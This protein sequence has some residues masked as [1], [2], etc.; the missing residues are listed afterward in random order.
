MPPPSCHSP[1]LCVPSS[2]HSP[3]LC[4]PSCHSP[5]LSVPSSSHSPGLSVTTSCHSPGLS[6]PSSCQSSSL[7]VPS[8]CHSPG[9]SV[10]SSCHSPGLSVPASC[11]SPGLRVPTSCHSPGLNVSS[12][13]H[14]PLPFH[15]GEGDLKDQKPL[16]LCVWK[17]LPTKTLPHK[18][19]A[20]TQDT[21][22]DQATQTQS[23][24]APQPGGD[25]LLPRTGWIKAGYPPVPLLPTHL[26]PLPSTWAEAPLWHLL[27]RGL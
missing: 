7:S 23:L 9:L 24:Q 27:S 18:G 21:L 8:S 19:L 25:S 12:F 3:G 1:G 5:G 20:E 10:P 15:N 14:S 13:C 16:P 6:V 17:G 2:C 22:S 26:H 11:H 4:G